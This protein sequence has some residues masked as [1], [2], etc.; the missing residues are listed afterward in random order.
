[1][2]VAADPVAEIE[3]QVGAAEGRRSREVQ[4]VELTH[5]QHCLATQFR[6]TDPTGAQ[7]G[8]HV[9]RLLRL[10]QLEQRPHVAHRDDRLIQRHGQPPRRRAARPIGDKY[11]VFQGR[12][13]HNPPA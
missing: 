13:P 6:R 2:A 8:G 12:F 5:R 7:D 9:G 10:H 1:M 3:S 4:R 11:K